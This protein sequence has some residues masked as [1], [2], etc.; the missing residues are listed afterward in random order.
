[1]EVLQTLGR[2]GQLLPCFSEEDCVE[3]EVAYQFQSVDVI[4]SNE[5]HDIP[6]RHPFQYG[7]ELSFLHVPVNPNKLQDVRMRD[8]SPENSLL[9]ESLEKDGRDFV[10]SD[11]K[12]I[13]DIHLPYRHEVVLL[14]NPQA[15]HR[16]KVSHVRSTSDI[17]KST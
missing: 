17:C 2:P 12:N 6:V 5:V 4:I 3:S 16:D 9:T 7:G 13:G 8:C 11:G 14:C 1:M 15:L 10:Q